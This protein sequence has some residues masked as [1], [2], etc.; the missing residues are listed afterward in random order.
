MIACVSWHM[1]E[2]RFLAL[3]RFFEY[4]RPQERQRVEVQIFVR[5]QHQTAVDS[6]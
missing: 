3:K 6:A 4:D 1:F 5:P 2:K